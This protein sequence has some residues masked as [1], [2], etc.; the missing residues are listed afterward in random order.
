[1]DSSILWALG[2]VRKRLP[3]MTLMTAAHV[4]NALLG[5][6]FALG[7]RNVIDS[8]TAGEPEAFRRACMIQ[9]VIVLGLLISQLLQRHL[10]D[11]V[12]DQLDRDWKELLLGRILGSDYSAVTHR[13][14]ALALCDWNIELGRD[15]VRM[16]RCSLPE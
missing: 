6:V 10:H 15:G 3:A 2:R 7:T 5:V 14:A 16:H 11:R 9:G 8:A 4:G 1:M 12:L 13:P